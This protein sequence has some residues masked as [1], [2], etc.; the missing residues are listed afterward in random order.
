MIRSLII[1]DESG[2]RESIRNSVQLFCPMVEI[3]GEADS[4]A[5]GKSLIN[6]QNPDLIFLDI[7]MTDG[8]GFDLLKDFPE[9]AFDIIFVTAYDQFALK[10]FRFSALDYLLKPIH[11]DDL[12]EAVSKVRKRLS[13]ERIS[14][15]LKLLSENLESKSID[16]ILLKTAESHHLVD[17]KTII[18]CESDKNYTTFYLENN[19]EIIISKTLK[20]YDEMLNDQGFFRVHQSYL[21]NFS[22]I[23]HY[24][25]KSGGFAVM[26][27]GHEVPVSSRK[28]EEFLK[29]LEGQF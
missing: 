21:I 18:Y 22:Q 7:Q 5:S 6:N 1:D 15:Q 10:A 4:V 2:A 27:N 17:I 11:P 25:K 9:P 8:T 23:D 14:Q 28:K 19:K 12:I 29:M 13:N 16:R 20:E 24:S 26:K 3:C